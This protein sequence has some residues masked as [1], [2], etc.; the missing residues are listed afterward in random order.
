MTTQSGA[1]FKRVVATEDTMSTSGEDEWEMEGGSGVSEL[2]R[3]LLED[4]R[5]RD[6]ELAEE[7]TRQNE[8]KRHYS[9]QMQEQL[10]MMRTL[11]ES[12][13]VGSEPDGGKSR[14][15]DGRSP[16]ECDCTPPH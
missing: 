6:H 2:V 9:R 10:H 7:R 8:E 13:G 11:V 16:E 15:G 3:L 5:K 14:G 12:T 1:S 4:R